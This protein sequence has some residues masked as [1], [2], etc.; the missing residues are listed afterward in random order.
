MINPDISHLIPHMRCVLFRIFLFTV[1]QFPIGQIMLITSKPR[2]PYVE[3]LRQTDD[4]NEMA[5]QFSALH[6]PLS[7]PPPPTYLLC[8]SN[9][10]S[11]SL[12]SF[13]YNSCLV[14]RIV[15]FY[16]CLIGCF[17]FWTVT[18][19]N[20]SILAGAILP[21][22]RLWLIDLQISRLQQTFDEYTQPFYY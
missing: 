2:P 14:Q 11:N 1:T 19:F 5:P 13:R 15:L 17:N 7:S 20:D 16:F 6:F 10:A 21:D 12:D 4:N 22:R 9:R 8:P 18:Q 3:T